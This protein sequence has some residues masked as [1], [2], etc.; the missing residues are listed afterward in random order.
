M[1]EADLIGY[2]LGLL[3][4]AERQAVDNHLANSPEH[5]AQVERLRHWLRLLPL[6]ESDPPD[7]LWFR[8]LLRVEQAPSAGPAV[9]FQSSR[10]ESVVAAKTTQDS[11]AGL[12]NASSARDYLDWST[13]TAP[14]AQSRWRIVDILVI[15][16]LGLL[17]AA[18]IPPAVLQAKSRE[19]IMACQ[20]NLRKFYDCLCQYA[21]QHAEQFPAVEE[22]GPLAHAG[23]FVLRLRDAGIWDHDL[24][25]VCPAN[26]RNGNP[27]PQDWPTLKQWCDW[28][29]A[30][31]GECRRLYWEWCR[32]LSGCYAYHLG[33][34][35]NGDRLCG[36][37]LRDEGCLPILADRPPRD[38]EDPGWQARNSPNHAGLGQNVL[39]VGGHVKFQRF[40]L[41]GH[42]RDDIYLNRDRKLAAGCD[43]F[44]SVLAP[45]EATPTGVMLT[46]ANQ[47]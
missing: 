16:V 8:T 19:K 37:T 24:S 11:S 14:A 22:R 13:G 26:R 40:R 21:Q 7:E 27:L 1:N 10:P 18:L 2:V 29:M 32:R 45:S 31:D 41:C 17:V 38:E 34:R 15:V 23:V 30:P 6:G 47:R 46:F 44:D 3:D 4:D 33:Y 12:G 9:G 25:V 42:L 35:T 28:G 43:R 5:R 36:L 39:Y 20:N